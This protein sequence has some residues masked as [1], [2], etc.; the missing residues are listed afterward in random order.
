MRALA[1]IALVAGCYDPHPAE[2][3]PCSDNGACPS[4]QTCVGT[5]CL[6]HDPNVDGPPQMIDGHIT[7]NDSDGDGIDNAV[8]N[9]PDVANPDQANEDGD[10]FGDACDPC[11]VEANDTPNDPDGDGVADGC[12]PHPTVAGDKIV[13][14]EGFANGIPSNWDVVGTTSAAAGAISLTT[15]ANNHTSVVAPGTFANATVS[16]SIQVDMQVGSF[17][18]ATTL[19]IPYDPGTDEGIFCELYAPMASSP[20]GRYEDLYSSLD[21]ANANMGELGN[22]GFGW[23]LA[24]PY[25]VSLTR[26]GNQY[27]CSGIEGA[28][29]HS[30]SG[31]TNS[32]PATFRATVAVYGSNATVQWMMV[33]SS[34]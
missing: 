17:D 15:V 19:A 31:N 33:V 3:V 14:F 28:T 13:V 30:T 22:T 10:K 4:G 27:K 6:T 9:C 32:L 34:P 29:T 7:A 1:I 12:D 25:R 18:S 2:G 20:N 24:T 23:Q 11:P 26:V 21:M 5:V 8:D 16:A